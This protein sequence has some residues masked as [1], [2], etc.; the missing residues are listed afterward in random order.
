MVLVLLPTCLHFCATRAVHL[1]L[2]VLV[3]ALRHLRGHT[4]S[5]AEARARGCEPGE[6]V[7]EQRS[8]LIWDEQLV[9]GLVLL[10]G[11]FPPDQPNPAMHHLVQ[12]N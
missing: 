8:I 7:L 1:A 11:S 10:E 12:E 2:L 4:I 6:R 9:R 3:H 5:I